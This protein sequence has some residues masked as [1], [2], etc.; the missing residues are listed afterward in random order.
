MLSSPAITCLIVLELHPALCVVPQ[1]IVLSLPDPVTSTTTD[2]LAPFTTM[3]NVLLLPIWSMV[4]VLDPPPMN[5]SLPVPES[6]TL[7]PVP[8]CVTVIVELS[9]TC[10]IYTSLA[11]APVIPAMII[12]TINIVLFICLCSGISR[13]LSFP[14][15]R[16]ARTLPVQWQRELR[17]W[18]VHLMQ[19]RIQVQGFVCLDPQIL[20]R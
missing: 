3:A 4:T 11:Q 14:P 10:S 7:L 12:A 20:T 18:W 16:S 2:A 19:R 9:P 1:L 17:M 5:A 6:P 13:V 15:Q 8:S